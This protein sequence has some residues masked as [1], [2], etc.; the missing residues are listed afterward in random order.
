MAETS[1]LTTN[2]R[3][4]DDPLHVLARAPLFLVGLA[5]SMVFVFFVFA[6]VTVGAWCED[7]I[8][9][10]G[11]RGRPRWLPA[12]LGMLVY[13]GGGIAAPAILGDRLVGWP[14]AVFAPLL[15]LAAIAKLGH[16]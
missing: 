8:R 6:W 12:V 4:I 10:L 11:Y 16:W 9:A 3:S 7:G 14:G 15:I 2:Q 13:A 1:P 5:I